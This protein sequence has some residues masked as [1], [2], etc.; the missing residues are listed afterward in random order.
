MT[1]KDTYFDHLEP[2]PKISKTDT[3]IETLQGFKISPQIHANQMSDR[4]Q[5]KNSK[6]RD[7]TTIQNVQFPSASLI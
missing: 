5:N 7:M 1:V 6:G 4:K 2:S 3:V